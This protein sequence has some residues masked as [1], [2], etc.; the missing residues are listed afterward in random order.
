[1]NYITADSLGRNDRVVV[2]DGLPYLV[3][4]V[5]EATDGGVL[6]QFSSGDTAHYAAED[7]V[8][9]VD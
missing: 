7:E 1:M 6:V 8:R 2:D 4:K 9:I 5:S 3:D